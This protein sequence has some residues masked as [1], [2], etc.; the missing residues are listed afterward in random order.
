MA[1]FILL[2]SKMA[3]RLIEIVCPRC[4][5]KNKPIPADM[6]DK[7]IKCCNCK[8]YI[9]YGWRKQKIEIVDRPDRDNSSGLTFC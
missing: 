5:V 8:K 1:I 6:G 3:P 2:E 7:V 4:K 9:H